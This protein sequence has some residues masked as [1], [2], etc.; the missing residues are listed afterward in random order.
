VVEG[1]LVFFG[2]T[3]GVLVGVPVG[4]AVLEQG[5]ATVA[6]PEKLLPPF[7]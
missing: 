1:V 4:V 3:F 6:G 5:M 2:V 7:Q